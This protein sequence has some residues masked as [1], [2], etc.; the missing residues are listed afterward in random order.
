[1]ST[2]IAVYADWEGLRTPQRLGWLHARRT[3]NSEK[4]EYEC[5]PA[6]LQ[7]PALTKV[8]IDPGIGAFAGA[9]YPAHGRD[10]F[11]VFA[12]SSPDRWGRMLMK[13]RLERDIRDGMMPS[14]AR[15]HES[16][17]LLGVHDLYRVG[18]L[19]YRLKDEGNFLDDQNDMAAPPFVELRALERASRELENDPDNRAT[20]GRDWLRML[21]APGG[22]L[23]GARP[24]ASVVDDKGNLWIAKFPSTRDTYDVGGWELVVNALA[25]AC[26]LQVA[27]AV[28]KRYASKE[29]CFMVKRFDRTA[30]HRRLHFASAMTLTGHIDGEDAGNGVSYMELAEVLMRHGSSPDRDLAELWKRIVFNILVSNT[31]DHLRN[32]GFILEPGKGWRLSDAYDLNPVP[33]GDG[34]KLNITEHDNALDLGLARE[35]AAYFRVSKG[36]AEDVISTCVHAVS[37]W[38][39]VAQALGL[40]QREQDYMAPA[41]GAK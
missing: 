33:H 17:F 25:K 21:I 30:S 4:F 39:T 29:H 32:H 1:M 15:M 40:S 14:G 34:L 18:A 31:D 24:K 26:G 19:R 13:R 5:D 38:R 37:H 16:G 10:M 35:V 36:Q 41:F 2:M 9:Q 12:D 7:D 28:A 11:G 27:S 22:S 23:G 8:Q 6:A 3:R 20:Q